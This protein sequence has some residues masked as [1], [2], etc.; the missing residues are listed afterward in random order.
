MIKDLFNN[1]KDLSFRQM[2][3]FTLSSLYMSD[4]IE[5]IKNKAPILFDYALLTYYYSLIST[6]VESA[7]TARESA[8]G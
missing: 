4:H 1:Y 3:Y 7:E 2:P 5:E 6:A 8:F